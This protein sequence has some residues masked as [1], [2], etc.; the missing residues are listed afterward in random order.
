MEEQNVTQQNVTEKQKLGIIII[1]LI[2][3]GPLGI[4]RKQLGYPK[5][6]MHII[7]TCCCFVP[8]LIWTQID[9]WRI[10]FGSLKHHDGSN[11]EI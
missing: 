6:W 9:Y 2:F 8:G 7:A 4:H 3:L 1:T 11:I 5:W 10:L